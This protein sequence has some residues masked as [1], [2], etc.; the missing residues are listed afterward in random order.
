MPR[1]RLQPGRQKIEGNWWVESDLA[2]GELANQGH[3]CFA[4][5]RAG[6]TTYVCQQPQ[7][8]CNVTVRVVP[9]NAENL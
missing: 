3:V 4:Y 1:I 7:R 2:C 6:P 9:G 5:Y 8:V